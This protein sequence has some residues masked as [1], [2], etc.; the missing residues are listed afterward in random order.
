[1][2][3]SWGSFLQQK[4]DIRRLNLTYRDFIAN[5]VRG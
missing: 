5:E 2:V 4:V 1:V 3:S